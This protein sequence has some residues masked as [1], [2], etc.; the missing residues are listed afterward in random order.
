MGVW[1]ETDAEYFDVSELKS[2]PAW[3][4]GLKQRI[5][6]FHNRMFLSHPAWVCGLK[7]VCGN[8][9]TL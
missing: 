8:G 1:I 7:P 2:H 9:S 3:V 5:E 4:C 6:S